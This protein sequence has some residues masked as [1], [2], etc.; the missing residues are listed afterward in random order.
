LTTGAASFKRVL[1]SG[2]WL[3]VFQMATKPAK[4]TNRGDKTQQLSGT[5]SALEPNPQ[6]DRGQHALRLLTKN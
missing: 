2:W 3:T 6:S 5:L 1:G 4:P